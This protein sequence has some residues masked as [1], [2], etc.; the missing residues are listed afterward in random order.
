MEEAIPI[1]RG[2][3]SPAVTP[4][5]VP[6]RVRP[7][8]G[9][10]GWVW[11]LVGGVLLCLAGAAI[12]GV[13]KVIQPSSVGT[14]TPTHIAEMA[15]SPMPTAEPTVV[16]QATTPAATPTDTPLPPTPTPSPVPYVGRIAFYSDRDGQSGIYVM[17]A[18]D[19][20]V[21]RLTNESIADCALSWSPDGTRIV[22]RSERDGNYEIYVMNAD[23]SGQTNLTNSPATDVNPSW[24]PDGTRIAFQSDRDGNDEIYVMNADGSG[25]TRLT[26]NPA[27]D[28][29]PS[30]GP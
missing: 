10:P 5:A 20:G 14:A 6:E 12:C 22:F 17:N 2:V 16:A 1:W 25:V 8:A 3:P 9:L 11:V 21:T 13:L 24:S 30:W 27:Y 28:G 23:G 18:D 7:R 4:V 15:G 29:E 19:S 26:D